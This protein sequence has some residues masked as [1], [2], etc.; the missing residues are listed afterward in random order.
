MAS[1]PTSPTAK[2][3]QDITCATCACLCDDIELT[4][5]GNRIVAVENA[6]AEGK[7]RFLRD[8]SAAQPACLI[9]GKPATLEQ[10][11][12]RAAQLLSAARYPLVFGLR[13][14]TI[15]TQRVALGIAD[16]L[17]AVIDSTDG[18]FHGSAGLALPKVGEST[19]S[20]GEVKNRGDLVIF[21][22]TDPAE[23]HP[24]HL[25]RYSFEPKGLFVPG[26]R[27]DRTCVVIDSQVNS[28]AAS[29]D[30]FLQIKPNSDFEAIWT[31]RAL[32]AGIEVDATLIEATTGQS[33]DAWQS[34]LTQMK[35]AKY[36]VIFFGDRLTNSRG[37]YANGDAIRALTRD[38]NEHTRFVCRFNR[39]EPNASGAENVSAWQTGYP[40]AVNLA[41]GYPRFS[42]GE[43][44]AT[45]VLARR[46]ADAALIV[47]G[48][49]VAALPAAARQHLATIPTIALQ[50]LDTP[51]SLS[52]TV[53]FNV[54]ASGIEVP[55]P[56]SPSTMYR[57]DDVPLPLRA[58]LTSPLPSDRDLLA[59]IEQRLKEFEV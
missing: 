21:W 42:P 41:A 39:R 49:P 52:S 57:L 29:A 12:E 47:S 16:A 14:T 18:D 28:T 26:G 4:I 6:C 13:Q 2:R 44:S 5:Q 17:G 1:Q 23:T 10:G 19:C 9:E 7:A 38:L 53:V 56:L 31:L 48:D 3:V 43:Y 37:L 33:L 22:G 11:I 25:D 15:E 30:S 20:L 46:E 36:G 8:R 27:V 24:R 58:V 45:A 50:S 32:L 55:G 54:A 51:S 34:L 35:Q 59:R 40:F